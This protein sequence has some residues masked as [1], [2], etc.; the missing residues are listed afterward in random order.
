MVTILIG[1]LGGFITG[2][3]PCILPVLPVIFLSGGAQSARN[4]APAPANLIG[5]GGGANLI[6]GNA[7]AP[8][9]SAAPAS[10]APASAAPASMST[11]SEPSRWRPYLVVGGL[12]LSFT[13]FT[14]LGSTVLN[15]LRLPQ[16]TIRWAGI[17]M[18]AALGIAMLFPRFMELLERPFE[19]FGKR[20]AKSSNGFVLGLVLGA[21]YVP[22]AGPVL[23]AIAVAGSTGKIGADTALLALSF[24]VGTAIPLLFFALAG[25]RLAERIS[26]FR[27]CQKA[28]R[29][30]AGI[31]LIALSIGMVFNLPAYLQRALPDWTASAQ[32]K[33]ETLLHGTASGA[34]TDGASE[35]GNCGPLAKIEGV[36]WFNTPGDAPITTDGKVTLVDFWAYSCINCQRSIPGVEKLYETYKDAG[37]NVIG[38]HSPEYA[39]EKE[40]RNVR[41]AAKDLGITYPVAVDSDLTTWTN[42]DNHYWPAHYLAD[43]AGQLRAIKYGEGG[44]ATTEKLVRE[45]LRDA[46]PKVSLPAPVFTSDDAGARNPRTPETYL[47]A[48]RAEYFVGEPITLGE[49]DAKLP[50]DVP[51]N[52]FAIGGKWTVDGEKITAAKGAQVA[53]NWFGRQV[54]VVASGNGTIRW[55]M[56][57]KSGELSVPD[58]PNKITVVDVPDGT[59]GVLTL[60]VDPGV[61]LYSF[62]F[63]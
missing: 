45:L 55:E 42:F 39:F 48:A 24:S 27:R 16:D 8:G 34:C 40:E 56:N 51:E 38:V 7:I 44:E 60:S 32:Q 54:H 12:V 1:L 33:T 30:G 18:L 10:A 37:L 57:G 15:L 59:S 4:S 52:R 11:Q 17:V 35:L 43:S 36:S 6:G 21:A 22:C 63:G 14:L 9:A 58:V 3:S 5:V 49:H 53:L 20:E 28:I 61:S 19:R 13:F 47:G 41:A 26:A 50:G 25:R 31:A 23:A 46:N 2:I 62:T 29:I